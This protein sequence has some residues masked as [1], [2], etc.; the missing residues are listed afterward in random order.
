MFRLH[1]L[2]DNIRPILNHIYVDSD[3]IVATNAQ[4][5]VCIP[6]KFLFNEGGETPK[7]FIKS[8]DWLKL[9]TKSSKF[10][11]Y[12]EPYLVSYDKHQQITGIIKPMLA[13]KTSWKYPD[14]HSVKPKGDPVEISHIAFRFSVVNR[15]RM[16]MGNM[17]VRLQFYGKN[18][19]ILVTPISK[20]FQGIWGLIMPIMD[21]LYE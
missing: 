13:S 14:Y 21:S 10:I 9:M 4:G 11:R 12:E 8:K 5:L 17:D 16:A 3:N 7:L 19:G 15:V 20:E 6:K 1:H 18:K 2:T